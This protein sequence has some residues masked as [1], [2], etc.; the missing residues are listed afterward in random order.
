MWCRAGAGAGAGCA[1][2]TACWLAGV[3]EQL[4]AHWR[5]GLDRARAGQMRLASAHALQHW[6]VDGPRARADAGEQVTASGNY[7]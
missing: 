4:G 5:G 2:G 6:C 7:R 3:G 1:A